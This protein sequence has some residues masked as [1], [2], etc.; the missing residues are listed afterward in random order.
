MG[1]DKDL[2][3]GRLIVGKP[4]QAS[5]KTQKTNKIKQIKTTRI[6]KLPLHV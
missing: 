1:D 3:K 2:L 5:Y 6:E 4:M